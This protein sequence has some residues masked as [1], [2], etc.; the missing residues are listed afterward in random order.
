MLL[1]KFNSM[2]QYGMILSIVLTNTIWTKMVK[3]PL[4][5]G[6]LTLVFSFICAVLVCK[7]I[8][9]QKK[10]T[11]NKRFCIYL[12]ITVIMSFVSAG[13][14]HDQRVT[15]V[16]YFIIPLILCVLF[17]G[18]EEN[19]EDFWK[20]FVNAVAVI[21]VISLVFY[22]SG[23]ILKILKPTGITTYTWTWNIRCNNWYNLYYESYYGRISTL[24]FL[25]RKNT[26]MYTEPPMFMVFVCTA[27]S[28]E[29]SFIKKPRKTML[30]VLSLT[31]GTIMSTTG[32]ICLILFIGLF[33]MLSGKGKVIKILKMLILPVII[34]LVYVFV[35]KLYM[36]KINTEAGNESGS[37]RINHMITAFQ[38]WLRNPLF[39]IGYGQ[40]EA[41]IEASDNSFGSS[42]GL[43]LFFAFSG[44][45]MGL[46]LLIPYTLAVIKSI[47]NN[48]RHLY[49]LF[50]MFFVLFLTAVNYLPIMICFM[51]MVLSGRLG[52]N[53]DDSVARWYD[54]REMQYLSNVLLY[55][56]GD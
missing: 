36:E 17:F 39:G 11:I 5:N 19:V 48:R 8:I 42:I 38:I 54:S 22:I 21:S 2:L 1:K 30:L 16:M 26:G 23:S 25:S 52:K 46:L 12:V 24:P 7:N 6:R 55:P 45:W 34:M 3:S 13:V 56:K 29:L 18:T 4:T 43:P 14:L 37:I 50:G 9:K 28:A 35:S 53:D 51:A 32:Y 15:Y 20:R 31:L 27:L 33:I 10:T 44:A 47:H 49:F 41:F 40:T